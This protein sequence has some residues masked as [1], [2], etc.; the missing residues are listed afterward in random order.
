MASLSI[1]DAVKYFIILRIFQNGKK[2][3]HQ[4]L[5][6]LPIQRNCFKTEVQIVPEQII[7][8]VE[9]KLK[10]TEQQQKLPTILLIQAK[11]L[12]FLYL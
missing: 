11:E 6:Q 3:N 9:E 1:D 2:F 12:L 10:V 4:H 8:K 5:Q 7:P